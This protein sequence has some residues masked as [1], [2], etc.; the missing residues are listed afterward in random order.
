MLFSRQVVS[1]SLWPP[2]LQHTR[3]PCLSLFSG[4][5]SN[6]CLLNRW[7]YLTISSS[8]TLFS[9]CLQSFPASGSFPMS[10]LWVSGGQSTGAS[11]SP[12]ALSMNIQGWF[13]LGLTGLISLQTMGLSRVFSSTI[14]HKHQFFGAQPFLWSNSHIYTWLLEKPVALTIWTFAGKAMSLLIFNTMSRF[15]KAFLP[16]SKRLLISWLQS[17]STVILEPTRIKSVTASTFALLFTMKWWDRM[18][19]S[20]FFYCWVLS[21]LFHSPLSPS[22]TGSLVPLCFLPLE[23]YNLHIW[24][25]WHFSQHSWFQV[26]IYPAWHFVWYI[27]HV[28]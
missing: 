8:A 18:P 28:S 19:R 1:D 11:A 2:G 9:F 15:V 20:Q 7:C 26:V 25:F 4:V 22:S 23:W 12:S 6:S 5:Y 24:G 3:L 16:R 17:P 27:L 21:Q 14:V 13:P 10:Q